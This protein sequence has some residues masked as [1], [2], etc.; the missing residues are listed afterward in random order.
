V[1]NIPKQYSTGWEFAFWYCQAEVT[2][3]TEPNELI[4]ANRVPSVTYQ[5]NKAWGSAQTLG[6]LTRVNNLVREAAK[7]QS[8]RLGSMRKMLK[9]KQHF[10]Q[11]FCGKKPV[12][13]LY[14]EMEFKMVEEFY[15]FKVSEV[16]K[17]YDSIPDKPDQLGPAGLKSY[18]GEMSKKHPPKIQTIEDAKCKRIPELLESTRRGKTT[19]N[20][21]VKGSSLSEKL[22]NANGGTSV[23]TIGRVI[24]SPLNK[25]NQNA[26]AN[27]AMMIAS[28]TKLEQKS[29]AEEILS[30]QIHEIAK[31]NP[32]EA[33]AMESDM[34]DILVAVSTYLDIIPNKVD[35]ET[36]RT[37]FRL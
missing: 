4:K 23:R 37:T 9:S 33:A 26:F 16:E 25:L 22:I 36:W 34:T 10:L 1:E 32:T 19:V 15:Q 5:A 27:R 24:W 11:M 28:L 3:I 17:L 7:A 13:G 12:R 35:N 30:S 20:Q 18:F 29:S 21:I 2:K 6:L 14:T 8:G 31:N